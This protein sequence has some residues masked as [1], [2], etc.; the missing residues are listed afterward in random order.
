MLPLAVAI[1]PDEKNRRISRLRLDVA[2][3]GFLVLST[4]LIS[5]RQ[6]QKGDS[7]ICNV[8]CG[9]SLEKFGRM[10]RVPFAVAFMEV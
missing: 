10:T 5:M 3:D 2:G 8:D 7:Y 9:R 6:E 4:W 1:R